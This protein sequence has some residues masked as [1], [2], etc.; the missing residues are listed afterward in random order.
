MTI[1][2]RKMSGLTFIE[3]MI[4][5]ALLAVL[6][7]ISFLSY[8]Q[9]IVSTN[10]SD[11]HTGLN[12]AAHRLQ[13]CY[14]AYS[15]YN[16]ADCGVFEQLSEPGGITSAETLYTITIDNVSATTYT[17]VATPAR[18]PQLGDTDC[19]T[20]SLTHTGRRLPEACW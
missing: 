20:I 2:K 14:T 4:V 7:M 13:R 6:A 5:F 19:P 18:A 12:D 15:A 1:A 9:Y 17:L 16:S 3:L 11:A 8:T 10:R